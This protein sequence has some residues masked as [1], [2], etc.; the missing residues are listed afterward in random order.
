MVCG[1]GY[2]NEFFNFKVFVGKCYMV[3]E[4]RLMKVNNIYVDY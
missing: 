2:S 3:V 4:I 1:K